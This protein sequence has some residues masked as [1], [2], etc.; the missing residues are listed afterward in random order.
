MLEQAGYFPVP[1]AHLYTVLHQVQD[2]V[3]RV[4]LV[5]PFASERHYA[6]RSL[7]C[8]ARYLAA[9]RVEVLRYDYRG[10]G[11][12][13]G[14]FEKMSFGDWQQD[15]H[16]L[17]DW[18]VKRSPSVPLMLH[19]AELGAI[20]AGKSFCQGSGNALLLW[21]PPVNANHVLRS[22]LL[23]WAGL[24]RLWE[25]SEIRKTA[26]EYIRQLEQGSSVEVHGYQ[27][28]SRLWAESFHFDM[29]SAI[30]GEISS[31]SESINPVKTVRFREDARSIV[32]PYARHPE[33]K[34]LSSLYSNN[35]N[36]M[37]DVL[38]LPGGG[39]DEGVN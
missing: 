4:L 37:A 24:E 34:D 11:E 3:A 12:S 2:P 33:V 25:S 20:L 1:D 27:W 5:G 39:R 32:M 7:V 21:S 16:L 6:Y 31:S 18:F 29:P 8:W 9:H 13:T 35:F 10:I 23:R 22:V 15:V 17:A 30:K 26:S 28:S 19:G 14:D 36:W 38:A